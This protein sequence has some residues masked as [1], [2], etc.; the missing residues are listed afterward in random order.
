MDASEHLPAA[1]VT[2]RDGD[3]SEE[4]VDQNV[5]EGEVTYWKN[6][7]SIMDEKLKV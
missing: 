3:T 2:T 1:G 6:E 4:D 7:C 5:L